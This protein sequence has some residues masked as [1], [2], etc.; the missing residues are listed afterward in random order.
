MVMSE[1]DVFNFGKG[2][3]IVI[4]FLYFK[5]KNEGKKMKKLVLFCDNC[6]G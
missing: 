2:S 1:L 5:L 4:S 6:P 3:N